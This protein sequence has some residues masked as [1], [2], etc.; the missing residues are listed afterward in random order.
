MNNYRMK[1]VVIILAIV[2]IVLVIILYKYFTNPNKKLSASGNLNTYIQPITTLANPTNVSYSYGIWIYV[3]SWDATV[4][5]TIFS[6]T[7]N[8]SV[9]LQ[10]TAPT[11]C[12]DITMNDGT[13][14]TM[15]ITNNFQLQKW[16]C[17]EI[18]V[19]N[20]F[21]DAYLD[22]KL[23][24]SQRMYNT[25]TGAMPAIPPPA[26]NPVYLGNSG[27]VTFQPFDAYTANFIN[28]SGPVDPQ[29]AW[30]TYVSGNNT[31]GLA[32]ILSTYGINVAVLKNNVLQSQ[33]SLM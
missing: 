12:V 26:A 6:R 11:L 16:V 9:Y 30:N 24:T 5:K 27:A 31:S 28:S 20:Q 22:G 7:S 19:D 15:V 1:P 33:F 10:Q 25:T 14:Q 17:I 21:V 29:T 18:S 23:V 2:I 13:T 32:S 8:I 4:A 3:N